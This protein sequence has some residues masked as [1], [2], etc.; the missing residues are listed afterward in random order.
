MLKVFLRLASHFAC[1][2][3]TRYTPRIVDMLTC[4]LCT[5]HVCSSCIMQAADGSIV[6]GKK[7]A[8]V[9][10]PSEIDPTQLRGVV[11]ECNFDRDKQTWCFM[12]ERSKCVFS[13][14]CWSMRHLFLVFTIRTC[15]LHR[16]CRA[17]EPSR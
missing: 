6:E 5:A 3:T 1:S 17:S 14:I 7:P 11:I 2:D 10:F 12:R 15:M 13:G 9:S 16:W 4:N 8:R